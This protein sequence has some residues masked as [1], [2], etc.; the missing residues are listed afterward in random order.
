MAMFGFSIAS[1]RNL[2]DSRSC[3]P[4]EWSSG[5]MA[6]L[7]FDLTT[8][9]YHKLDISSPCASKVLIFKIINI[10]RCLFY[11]VA[12]TLNVLVWHFDRNLPNSLKFPLAKVSSN[13]LKKLSGHQMNCMY[14][15]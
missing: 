5:E 7:V 6:A 14:M 10:L 3:G 1:F 2:L 12:S 4:N 11:L 8:E 9:K 15:I 13:G